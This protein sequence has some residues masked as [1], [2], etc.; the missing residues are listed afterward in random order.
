M[1]GS[2]LARSWLEIGPGEARSMAEVG[3]HLARNQQAYQSWCSWG[4]IC[5]RLGGFNLPDAIGQCAK[6]TLV[7]TTHFGVYGVHRTGYIQSPNRTGQRGV[8]NEIAK[9]PHKML[10]RRGGVGFGGAPAT[11]VYTKMKNRIA[12]WKNLCYRGTDQWLQG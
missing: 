3:P 7:Y 12:A 4:E 9:K 10:T 8:Y 5:S 1:A 2:E 11:C 6:D